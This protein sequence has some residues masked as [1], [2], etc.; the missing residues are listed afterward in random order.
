MPS[1]DALLARAR[2]HDE[3]TAP[4]DTVTYEDC[5][6]SYFDAVPPAREPSGDT[7]S[8]EL[9]DH[10]CSVVVT[11]AAP[12][13]VEFLTGQLP[14]PDAA[15]LLGCALRL[16]GVD[17]G[18]RFWWQY[19]AG[20]EFTQAA[21][22]LSLYHHARGEA[23]AAAFWR[24]QSGPQTTADD[25]DTITVSGI[26][27]PLHHFRFDASVPTVLRILS[28]LA[29]SGPRPRT[30]R[31]DAITNYVANA[32]TRGYRRHPGIEIPVPE[33]RFADRVHFILTTTPPWTRHVTRVLNTGL[34]SRRRKVSAAPACDTAAEAPGG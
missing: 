29:D 15:W 6:Y 33:A 32:V 26:C 23:H 4:D 8:A 17:E 34:P 14:E 19:A 3:H 27:P 7:D 22:C 13:A 2:L 20:A 18:A 12:D 24:D 28:H 31:A 9:L 30:H 16:A 5:A 25:G 21:Y 11:A 10:L 1:I